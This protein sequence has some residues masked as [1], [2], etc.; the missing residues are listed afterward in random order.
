MKCVL[1][2]GLEKTGTTAIQRFMTANRE[3]LGGVGVLYP[4]S[5]GPVG[6]TALAAYAQDDG[7]RDDIRGPFGIESDKDL[8][9]FRDRTTTSLAAAVRSHSG[10]LCVLSN[11]HC[12]SRLTD[13]SEI[14]RLHALLRPLFDRI[15]VLVYLRRQDEFLLSSYSTAIKSGAIHRLGVPDPEFTRHRYRYDLLLERWAREFG[16]DSVRCRIYDRSQLPNGD[17][18]DDFTRAIGLVEI[19]G[20]RRPP[21]LN[22]SLD[23]RLLEYLRLLNGRM[24]TGFS[25][26]QTAA[27]GRLVRA[28]QSIPQG[29]RLT[30]PRAQLDEFMG[31]LAESN[32]IVATKYLRR[33]VQPD[34]DP[35]FGARDDDRSDR[36]DGVD[37]SAEDVLD[38]TAGL[39]ERL[40][41]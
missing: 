21:N 20:Y 32:A 5:L 9:A 22:E 16:T 17:V 1:H 15:E 39:L 12:S 36:I 37:L 33:E 29:S 11:E 2:I 10:P 31:S 35:L 13:Y 7:A 40:S 19:A 30:L 34:G 27:R 25:S 8:A 18:I 6:H 28:L 24:S 3:A 4:A 14:A 23:A 38:V 41:G 26:G